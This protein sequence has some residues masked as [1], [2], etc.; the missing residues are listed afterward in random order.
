MD[1]SDVCIFFV[2][3]C[4]GLL[5]VVV[6]VVGQIQL[7]MG[8]CLCVLEVLV[9]QMLFQCIVDGFVFIDEGMVVMVSVECM[10]EE[11]FVFEC[12]LVSCESILSGQLW[13][14]VLDWF[15]SYVLMLVLVEFVWQY[16]LVMV[17]LFIDVCFYSLVWCEVDLVFCIKVFDELDVILCC[18]L[19][20]FY[21]FYVYCDQLCLCKGGCGVWLVI[22]NVVFGGMFDVVWVKQYLFEVSVV[23]ISNS[24]DVQVCLCV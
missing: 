3:V 17:E 1:W 12:V 8:W 7:I 5:G 18:L 10:E 6:C 4:E 16:F 22:M 9:G 23:F 21:V 13:L 2:I 24:C 14:V 20:M 11:V 15:G 19:C